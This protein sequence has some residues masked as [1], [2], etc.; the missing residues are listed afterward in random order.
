MEAARE[1]A[2]WLSA[3]GKDQDALQ[4]LADAFTIAGLHSADAE[5]ANDRAR[6]GELYRKL[7]G[8]DTGLGDLILKAYDT[9]SSELAARRA[10]LREFDPNSQLKDPIAIHALRP[11]WRQTAA[12]FAARQSGGAG[13][14]G[15]LVRPLPRA[16]SAL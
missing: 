14:L 6:M 16:A 15:H 1:A 9:T 2:R 13:F 7:H 8:S 10:E 11:G 3:A 4:Y 12:L 5:G